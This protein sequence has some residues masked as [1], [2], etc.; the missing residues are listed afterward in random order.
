MKLDPW[1]QPIHTPAE[2]AERDLRPKEWQEEDVKR[3]RNHISTNVF[4]MSGMLGIY[5][6]SLII[7]CQ[8]EEGLE[9][10][11]AFE[12]KAE[13]LKKELDQKE[14][15]AKKIKEELNHIYENSVK[16]NEGLGALR[17]GNT[18]YGST[19]DGEI[20]RLEAVRHKDY[21]RAQGLTAQ[22]NVLNDARNLIAQNI[23]Q[24]SDD[25][26]GYKA[27]KVLRYENPSMQWNFDMIRDICHEKSSP[28]KDPASIIFP[29]I[30]KKTEWEYDED[31]T[32]DG[33]EEEIQ[34]NGVAYIDGKARSVLYENA[35]RVEFLNHKIEALEYEAE[36]RTL[37]AKEQ[38]EKE[39]WEA[40]R[41]ELVNIP[42]K[43]IPMD[44]S[45]D[46]V[47]SPE[48]VDMIGH[49]NQ[50]LATFGLKDEAELT[51][52]ETAQIKDLEDARYEILHGADK[53]IS[54]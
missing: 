30:Q 20:G 18:K 44:Y 38:T 45:W 33:T 29:E 41:Y 27:K 54:K 36:E 8:N 53:K 9:E 5:C 46:R 43:A 49:I 47:I 11:A 22:W 2:Q 31:F 25:G 28:L 13:P 40:E 7:D 51:E 37:T 1:G 52:A 32:T 17:L 42:R 35:Q 26:L 19:P 10:I 23:C 3:K 16:M 14:A 21:R 34:N 4:V 24:L 50:K 12:K 48:G 39:Q 6:G 15:A